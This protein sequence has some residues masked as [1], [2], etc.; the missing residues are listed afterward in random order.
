MDRTWW[1]LPGPCRFVTG[2]VQDLE[3]GKNVLLGLPARAPAGLDEA[4]EAAIR[5]SD[6]LRF[7]RVPA[8]FASGGVAHLVER[9]HQLYAPP[10]DPA[11][12]LSVQTLAAAKGMAG[13]VV[14]VSGLDAMTWPVWNDF[15]FRYQHAAH[16]RREW[17]RGLFCVPAAGAVADGELTPDVT[18][19][20]RRWRGV[21]GS[22]DLMLDLAG[23]VECLHAHR[24]HRQL[25]LALAVELAGSDGELGR[26]LIAQDL[27]TLLKPAKVLREYAAAAGWTNGT[28][29]RPTWS[30]GLA[31]EVDGAEVTHAAALAAHDEPMLERRIWNAQVRVLFP[32][33]EQE[34]VR[35]APIIQPFLR[36]PVPTPNGLIYDLY[37][38][39]L[40]EMY[41]HLRTSGLPQET[42]DRM[43]VLVE[44]RHALAHLKPVPE[45][46]L[47]DARLLRSWDGQ[48][49]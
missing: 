10:E 36:L 23:R 13:R 14:W 30:A 26:L 41:H 24:L 46:C 20:V 44:M 16:A 6:R 11:L 15:L 5:L 47:Y 27:L 38:L 2:V 1:N 48:A 31:D 40:G 34:R 29:K 19:S 42:K 25:A 21:V 4:V 9:L 22:L 28:L 39:E 32:F 45:R 8:E 18:V 43:A 7:D 37:D 35:L 49:V 12:V 3:G 17:E 33:L